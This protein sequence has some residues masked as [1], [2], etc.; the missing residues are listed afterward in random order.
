MEWR[1]ETLPYWISD[2]KDLLDVDAVCRLLQTTYWAGHRTKETIVKSM[3]N[4]LCF[5]VYGEEGQVGFMRV[6]TDYATFSWICDVI[7]HPDH[8]RQGLAKWMLK[9][10]LSHEAVRDTSMI[11]AT[12]D[13][14]GLYERFGFK[15]EELMRRKKSV[16]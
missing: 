5:G 15:R 3:E 11:L 13:A 7:I 4:S 6:V 9:F 14:H 1:H 2:Q 10:L 12:R 16:D 8:R